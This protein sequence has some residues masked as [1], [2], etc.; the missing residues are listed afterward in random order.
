MPAKVCK[1]PALSNEIVDQHIIG[2]LQSAFEHSRER[3]SVIAIG[4]RVSDSIDLDDPNLQM[5]IELL[6]QMPRKYPGD[7]IHS[8]CFKGVYR[9]QPSSLSAEHLPEGVI[10]NIRQKVHH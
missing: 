6:S 5:Q 2:G 3:Q 4:S 9:Q 7:R 8:R 1:C 10:K